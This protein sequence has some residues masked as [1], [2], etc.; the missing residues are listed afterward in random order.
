[1]GGSGPPNSQCHPKDKKS[2]ISSQEG[3]PSSPLP[4]KP[5]APWPTLARAQR[6]SPLHEE[7][8]LLLKHLMGSPDIVGAVQHQV[9]GAEAGEN[10]QSSHPSASAGQGTRAAGEWGMSQPQ[11]HPKPCKKG[12]QNG[13]HPSSCSHLRLPLPLGMSGWPPAPGSYS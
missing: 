12:Q 11:A 5:A 2:R 4:A 3:L 13:N 10:R 7:R 6:L 9:L 1:M 8:Q